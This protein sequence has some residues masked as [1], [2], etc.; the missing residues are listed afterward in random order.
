V[1]KFLHL[2]HIG[3]SKMKSLARAYF[4]W[5]KMDD[6]ITNLAQST[7]PCA[8]VNKSPNTAQIIPWA[9]P[10]RPWSRVH[11]DFFEVGRRLVRLD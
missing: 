7:Q 8:L 3:A 2:N 5:P 1:L 10:H 6:D 4:W 11:L 9:I